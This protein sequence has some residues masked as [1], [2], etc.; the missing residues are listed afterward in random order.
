MDEWIDK[1][2]LDA[3]VFVL[4]ANAESTIMQTVSCR[5]LSLHLRFKIS[6]SRSET[7]IAALFPN[8]FLNSLMTFGCAVKINFFQ[9]KNFFHRVS[10][11]L[12]KPNIFILNNRWDAS[13]YEIDTKKEVKVFGN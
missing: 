5:A 7:R 3:D 12:S 2:C 10:S 4:V 9:E 1:F 13:A 11:R 8:S 6:Y